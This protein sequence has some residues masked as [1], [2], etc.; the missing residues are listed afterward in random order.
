MF[1]RV[2]EEVEGVDIA[3]AVHVAD[4]RVRSGDPDEFGAAFGCLFLDPCSVWFTVFASTFDVSF[5]MD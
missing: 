2:S 1:I 3:L 5:F 4:D